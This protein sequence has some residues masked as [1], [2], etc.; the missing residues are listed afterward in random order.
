MKLSNAAVREFQALHLQKFGKPLPKEIAEAD[1]MLLLKIITQI[2]T[3]N[4]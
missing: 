2:R 3:S 4:R 1:F